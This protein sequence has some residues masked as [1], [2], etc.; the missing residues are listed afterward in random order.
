M[1]IIMTY[2]LLVSHE[3]DKVTVRTLSMPDVTASGKTQSEAIKKIRAKIEA[4]HE[5]GLIVE[6]E[7]APP[8]D[9]WMQF[10]GM[11]ADIPDDI[12]EMF[13]TAIQEERTEI[14]DVMMAI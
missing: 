14:D 1:P 10:A 13:Q 3:T 12:W 11:W 2:K 4:L 9:P 8:E 7:I 6:L 5:Q